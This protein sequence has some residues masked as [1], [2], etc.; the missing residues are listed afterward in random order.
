[1]TVVVPSLCQRKC[2]ITITGASVLESG[3]YAVYV[4]GSDGTNGNGNPSTVL[5]PEFF[6]LC[7][8]DGQDICFSSDSAGL[9]L[10]P[11][12][13]FN[14][15]GQQF[16]TDSVNIWVA[17]PLTAGTDVT[18]YVWYQNN[19]TTLT[20]PAD[21]DTYGSQAV[22][23]GVNGVGGSG[24]QLAFVSHDGGFS[25]STR[26]NT[27]GYGNAVTPVESNGSG[28]NNQNW[29]IQ[30]MGS[31]QEYPVSTST[32]NSSVLLDLDTAFTLQMW[33]GSN[34]NYSANT[35]NARNIQFILE[36]MGASNAFVY[37]NG[38]SSNTYL[39]G[40]TI[41]FGRHGS[42]AIYTN[43]SAFNPTGLSYDT[44][45]S[46][47]QHVITY[48][49]GGQSASHYSFG[50][51]DDG[52]TMHSASLS[53]SGS[54]VTAG[55]GNV[56]NIGSVIGDSHVNYGNYDEIRFTSTN[57]SANYLQTDLT[58]QTS[59][60]MVTA[61]TPVSVGG[62]PTTY[63]VD[64]EETPTITETPTGQTTRNVSATDTTT[65]T[66]T[67]STV[68]AEV[69][70]QDTPDIAER[71]VGQIATVVTPVTPN[72]C[73]RVCKLTISGSLVFENGIYACLFDGSQTNHATNAHLPLPDELFALSQGD[74]GDI[75]FTDSEINRLPV[76]LVSFDPI[77]GYCQ[78]WVAIP[79]NAG[80]DADIYV[81]Y[82]SNSDLYLSQPAATDTY[83]RH[84]VWNGSKGVGGA[85]N[86]V[87]FVSHDGGF[88]DATDN[89]TTTPNGSITHLAAETSGWDYSTAG[90]IFPSGSHLIKLANAGVIDPVSAFTAQLWTKYANVSSAASMTL[91]VLY[92]NTL[93]YDFVW[94]VGTVGSGVGTAYFGQHYPGV[95][96]AGAD[97]AI[98]SS[99]SAPE[100]LIS[101]T[102]PWLQQSLSFD[103]ASQPVANTDYVY[104][105]NG[106]PITL[107][108]DGTVPT[109]SGVGQ[110][111]RLGVD[112]DPVA[113]TGSY[114]GDMGEI[115]L[116]QTQ[117]SASYLKT[118]YS[119]QTNSS[120]ITVSTPEP[121]TDIIIVSVV[122][123]DMVTVTES[124]TDNFKLLSATDSPTVIETSDS[125]LKILSATD[126][127]TVTDSATTNHRSVATVDSV[128]ITE[129]ALIVNA[130]FHVSAAD[131][132]KFK[133]VAHRPVL[134]KLRATN[135]LTFN[136]TTEL[137]GLLRVFAL[138]DIT[139]ANPLYFNP[140]SGV[141]D[142]YAD[143]LYDNAVASHTPSSTAPDSVNLGESAGV[144]V[145]P[146][147]GISASATDT[148]T[149]TDAAGVQGE[150][151]I[152]QLGEMAL[153]FVT[154]PSVDQ[155]NLGERASFNIVRG[156]SAQDILVVEDSFFV[157]VPFELA[158]RDY[159]P[160]IGKGTN[161]D[162]APPPSTLIPNLK[163]GEFSLYY[164]PL[165]A[166]PADIV[167]LRKPEFG[168]KDRLQFNRIS[169]ET[170]GGTLV[171]FA[172]PM[173]PKTQTL[174]LTFAALKPFQAF[175]L[176]R[177]ME[178]YIGLEIGLMDWEG[179]QWTGVIIN[180]ND[181][182]V[183]DSKYSFTGSFEF[184]GQLVSE[185]TGQTV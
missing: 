173:W 133:E 5:P 83:G 14:T 97:T 121:A 2:P 45:S 170:R 46:Y 136:E 35:S 137:H 142:T 143:G 56:N 61:G 75:C 168:N 99:D 74:G 166:A 52:G 120:L 91:M 156:L 157:Y 38:R 144:R 44:I 94:G 123:T 51:G 110:T 1:M 169:R 171:V 77:N 89:F 53:T 150:V 112:S 20:Q 90:S 174:V 12:E 98:T 163:S 108:D 161:G 79:L 92:S 28:Y 55:S 49:G 70:Y 15:S 184:E 25:D 8:S 60:T 80:D 162:P 57:R 147:S 124:A 113:P 104:T 67:S 85:S 140:D 102:N 132:V 114:S 42:P 47:Y 82:Q 96:T 158:K 109:T 160:F 95:G 115:R 87:K 17:V 19:G 72:L 146:A 138:D 181:P 22:W 128:T 172:D 177:F 131:T 58:L 30:W 43:S 65:F 23:N 64:A 29:S 130:T 152:I 73:A 78:I 76:E 63:N 165:P 180:P 62:G 27:D 33:I 111:T 148:L 145:I 21:T 71:A 117:R 68:V 88:T 40:A 119:V 4:S 18:I 31:G 26:D 175:N 149:I 16:D 183:Q 9:N 127:V 118:D 66:E 86:K 93:S 34:T 7:Q 134:Y 167:I 185:L 39:S 155:L 107:S 176:Q 11:M 103:G 24:N 178:T 116:T 125:G 69:S 59:S 10:L 101:T 32:P 6:T 50:L 135:S 36:L 41:Y 153:A 179:R 126:S 81:W 3:I 37:A 100:I 129:I 48:D 141:I 13:F 182:V 154:K 139:P 106:A 159:H 54:N 105:V 122:A 84:A 164:P 151:D